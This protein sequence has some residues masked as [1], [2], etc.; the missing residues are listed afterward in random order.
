MSSKSLLLEW[1]VYICDK[2]EHSTRICKLMPDDVEEQNHSLEILLSPIFH[3]AK[4]CLYIDDVDLDRELHD[5]N[6]KNDCTSSYKDK[7]VEGNVDDT[8]SCLDR[9]QQASIT[10]QRMLRSFKNQNISVG[11]LLRVLWLIG[12][13]IIVQG[14]SYEKERHEIPTTT[15]L[16][17]CGSNFTV[18]WQFDIDPDRF[19]CDKSH[20]AMEKNKPTVFIDKNET[21]CA[22]IAAYPN[23][24]FL[25]RNFR[26]LANCPTEIHTNDTMTG[27]ADNQTKQLSNIV[28]GTVI[29]TMVILIV[30]IC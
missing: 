12:C 29:S 26:L 2:I 18:P 28:L 9:G 15:L 27:S 4:P 14:Q 19:M 24:T 16:V 22:C 17:A 11:P 1:S 6:E 3:G 7:V 10:R 21:I 8:F 13:C 25:E 5:L 23:G 20:R 30:I